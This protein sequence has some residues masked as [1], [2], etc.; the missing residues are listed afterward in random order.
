ME[1]QE[2]EMA[3]GGTKQEAIDIMTFYCPCCMDTEAVHTGAYECGGCFTYVLCE[4]CLMT[5]FR[6]AGCV[7]DLDYLRCPLC[8]ALFE[9]STED[10]LWQIMSGMMVLLRCVIDDIPL[11]SKARL[12]Y[13]LNL[14]EE[15]TMALNEKE[16]GT[17]WSENAA[18][19]ISL[20]QSS[21]LKRV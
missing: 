1:R 21:E 9:A 14:K 6:E 10:E 5:T 18:R 12:L 11:S 19:I 20:F 15:V 13:L 17:T 4:A 7:G 3:I 16:R 8:R 2:T